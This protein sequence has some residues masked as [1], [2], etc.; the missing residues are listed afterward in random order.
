M[1]GA[2]SVL[3]RKGGTAAKLVEFL[4]IGQGKAAGN[5]TH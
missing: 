4:Q 5:C 1:P 3:S 2:S